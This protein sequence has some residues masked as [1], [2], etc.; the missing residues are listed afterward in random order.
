[1]FGPGAMDQWNQI[2]QI[3][4][5]ITVWQSG[6]KMTQEKASWNSESSVYIKYDH[7]FPFKK[8]PDDLDGNYYSVIEWSGAMQIISI[9]S[10]LLN[11]GSL[12]IDAHNK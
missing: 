8:N 11:W 12:N 2:N 5:W 6:H 4:D 9:F 7:K 1:M 3:A 10:I